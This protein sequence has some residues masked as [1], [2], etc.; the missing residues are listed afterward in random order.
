MRIFLIGFMGSGKSS[1]GKEIA[2]KLNY[3]FIDI[4]DFIEKKSGKKIYEIFKDEGE[5]AFRKIERDCLIETFSNENIVI[6]TGG[7][8]PCFYNNM[9]LINLHGVSVYIKF[10]V[11]ILASRLKMNVEKRP[12]LLSFDKTKDFILHI[13]NLMQKREKFYLRSKIIIEGKNITSK[14]IITALSGFIL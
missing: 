8:T 3:S 5:E 11:G 7:G 1:M 9:E 12:L 6:A 4:D 13:E 14:K 10:N 2:H